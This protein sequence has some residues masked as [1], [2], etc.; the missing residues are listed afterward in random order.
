M[1]EGASISCCVGQAL[2]TAEQGNA[3]PSSV[4]STTQLLPTGLM[5]ESFHTLDMEIILIWAIR[6]RHL[7]KHKILR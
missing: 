5:K 3:F 1:T 7:R 6:A 2:L 4:I